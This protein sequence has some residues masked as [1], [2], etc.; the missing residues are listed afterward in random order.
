[1]RLSLT[2]PVLN[3]QK[4][5][6]YLN[7][8]LGKKNTHTKSKKTGDSGFLGYRLGSIHK[9]QLTT[10]CFFLKD[11]RDVLWQIALKIPA[12]EYH[13]VPGPTVAPAV[14]MRSLMASKECEDGRI[15]R[16]KRD[17]G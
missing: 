5:I 7:I 8:Y 6:K 16:E 13:V 15:N 9:F 2:L 4:S 1:M 11:I 10:S 3:E 17:L 12:P 14:R